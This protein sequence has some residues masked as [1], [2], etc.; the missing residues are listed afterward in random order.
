MK[1]SLILLSCV[2]FLSTKPYARDRQDSIPVA[3]K[4]VES[5]DAIIHS[6][7]NVISGPA[8]EKRNW[9]RMRTLFIPEGRMIAVGKTQ[10]G[11][12]T[13]RV[14]TVEDYIQRSGPFLET[15]GFFENEIGRTTEQF[16]GTAQ[17]MSAYD[18]RMKPEDEKPFARGINSI[19]LWH[20]GKRWWIVNVFWQGETDE[21]KIPEK[22]LK[23]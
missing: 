17:V 2:A 13:K 14:M 19:Q 10:A 1:K 23:N 6:L 21:F 8:G 18:S 20:D 12:A 5:I 3:L 15:N 22:Y 4:D 9:E 7:Y 11:V 16:G